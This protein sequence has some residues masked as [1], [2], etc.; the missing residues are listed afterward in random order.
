MAGKRTRLRNQVES[1]IIQDQD[2]VLDLDDL[3]DE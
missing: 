3:Q 2:G 1:M